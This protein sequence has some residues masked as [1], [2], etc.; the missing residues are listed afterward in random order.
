VLEYLAVGIPTLASDLPGTRRVAGDKPGVVLVPP[1][2]LEA[3][4]H[5]IESA[6]TNEELRNA[7]R[8]GAPAIAAEYAWP[9]EA[10]S[11]FYWDLRPDID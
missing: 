11:E 4:E 9:S 8:A 10:V 5:A 3:W 2:D 1:G 6:L 7:A